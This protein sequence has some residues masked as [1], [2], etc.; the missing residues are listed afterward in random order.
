MDAPRHPRRRSD[1]VRRL[2]IEAAAGRSPKSPSV[3]ILSISYAPALRFNIA[4][5]IEAKTLMAPITLES[6][7]RLNTPSAPLGPPGGDVISS[8]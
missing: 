1:G 5:P 4:S 2:L 8:F 3:R 6:L 7:S